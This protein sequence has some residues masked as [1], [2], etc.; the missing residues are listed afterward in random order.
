MNNINC[1]YIH[2]IIWKPKQMLFQ[3]H[4]NEIIFSENGSV[5]VLFTTNT[6][7]TTVADLEPRQTHYQSAK[8]KTY[9]IEYVLS[10]CTK[11]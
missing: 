5:I 1:N 11:N 3:K 6:L 8:S 7:R 4:T 2:Y 10:I 9:R